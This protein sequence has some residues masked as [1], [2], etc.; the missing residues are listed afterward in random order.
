[1]EVFYLESLANSVVRSIF[2]EFIIAVVKHLMVNNTKELIDAY[3]KYA[4]IKQLQL[5][6]ANKILISV[7]SNNI[8]LID[9]Q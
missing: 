1:M 4:I 6:Q 7:R 9:L 8:Y 3:L 5:Y 2:L